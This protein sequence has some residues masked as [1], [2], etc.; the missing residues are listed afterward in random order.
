MKPAGCMCRFMSEWTGAGAGDGAAR[1]IRVRLPII[2]VAVGMARDQ[3]AAVVHVPAVVDMGR[4]DSNAKKFPTQAFK[5]KH[6][7]FDYR[8]NT[9][10]GAATVKPV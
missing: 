2:P 1:I 8:I 6:L 3:A 10:N 9:N 5:I 4:G 7:H